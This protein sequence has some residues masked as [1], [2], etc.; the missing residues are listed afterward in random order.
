MDILPHIFDP[1]V[2]GNH[3]QTDTNINHH[4]LG[5]YIAAYYARKLGMRLNI[6]NQADGVVTRIIFRES[7]EDY[8]KGSTVIN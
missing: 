1:F 7:E 4:G 5:L 3:D 8:G 2:S 6:S